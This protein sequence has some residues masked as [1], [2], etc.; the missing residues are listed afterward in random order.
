MKVKIKLRDLDI[1]TCLLACHEE[2]RAIN[3][4]IYNKNN[5]GADGYSEPNECFEDTFQNIEKTIGNRNNRGREIIDVEHND[6]ERL[7]IYSLECG[8]TLRN[9]TFFKTLESTKKILKKH[10]IENE[11]S[12]F[13]QLWFDDKNNTF[14]KE[15]ICILKKISYQYQ[16]LNSFTDVS[17]LSILR[18]LINKGMVIETTIGD[19]SFYCLSRKHDDSD[20]E[21]L[22]NFLRFEFKER[23]RDEKAFNAINKYHC[24]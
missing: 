8:I 22:L 18:D 17:K 6:L 12:G 11:K 4:E 10:K 16:V 13:S 24:L 19:N 21:L 23:E 5:E 9:N 2:Q 1:F 20:I 15:E 14:T 7:C 3:V